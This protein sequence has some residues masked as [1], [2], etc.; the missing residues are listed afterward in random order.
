MPTVPASHALAKLLCIDRSGISKSSCT[1]QDHS[2]ILDVKTNVMI[3]S[4][5]V[6]LFDK[7][8]EAKFQRWHILLSSSDDLEN[9]VN[10]QK[11]NKY[12]SPLE[13]LKMPK[14]KVV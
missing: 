1:L 14:V 3:T 10:V 5:S 6:L 2:E 4:V 11:A 8:T 7:N 12:R 9:G 13:R